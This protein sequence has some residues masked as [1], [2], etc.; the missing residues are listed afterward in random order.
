MRVQHLIFKGLEVISGKVQVQLG[1]I[2][3]SDTE[4]NLCSFPLQR[5][6][7]LSHS[8]PASPQYRSAHHPL[9]QSLSANPYRA[10]VKRTDWASLNHYGVLRKKKNGNKK[11]EKE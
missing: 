1:S 10:P 3:K 7:P 2:K 6:V 11:K 5:Q 4:L 8:W 9:C